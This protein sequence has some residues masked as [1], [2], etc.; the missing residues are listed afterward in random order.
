MA[1]YALQYF[2]IDEFLDETPYKIVIA[3]YCN[4]IRG[5]VANLNSDERRDVPRMIGYAENVVPRYIE[6][7]YRAHFRISETV[8]RLIVNRLR[9]PL[10]R[11]HGGGVEQ[12]PAYKQSLISYDIWPI[13]I[14]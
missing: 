5:L 13:P 6:E 4:E 1:D 10:T 12:I 9:Q 8:F 14:L 3:C 7:D 2:I 11:Q